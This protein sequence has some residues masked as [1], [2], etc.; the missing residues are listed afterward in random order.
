MEGE[1]AGLAQN[2]GAGDNGEQLGISI[3][4]LELDCAPMFPLPSFSWEP[5]KPVPSLWR[6]IEEQLAPSERLEVKTILGI[7]FVEH[8]L[9][10]HNEAKTLLEFYQELQLDH[11]EQRPD[12]CILLAAPPHLK[13]LV[14]EEIRLLLVG[15]Q[16]KALEEGRDHDC[17]IAKYNTHV[18]NFAFKTN[19]GGNRPSSR[20]NNLIRSLS[21]NSTND[22]E[23]YSDKLNITQIGEIASRLRTLLEDECHALERYITH[24]QNQLEEVHQHATELQDKMHE[25]TMAE[26]QEEKRVMERD[27][28]LSLP[29]SCPRPPSPMS[30]QLGNSTHLSQ[31]RYPLQWIKPFVSHN[32]FSLFHSHPRGLVKEPGFGQLNPAS[33]EIPSPDPR[34][35]ITLLCYRPSPRWSHSTRTPLGWLHPK[36]EDS[37]QGRKD[38]DTKLPTTSGHPTASVDRSA[39]ASTWEPAFLPMPPTEPCPPSRFCPRVRLLQCKGPS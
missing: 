34:D 28:Q 6:M 37:N 16:Q 9:E 3:V 33:N 20:S 15:L 17:A 30:N 29:K 11:F 13:E 8:S 10:L 2:G 4:T 22:L 1:T 31:L 36:S 21:C 14:R 19:A 25:P 23:P 24:L 38:S 7:D 27:L 39:S 32:S 12:N 35:Q 18:I 5:L 26:L